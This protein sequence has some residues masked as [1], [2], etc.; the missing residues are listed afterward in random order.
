MREIL[1]NTYHMT[2]LVGG[3]FIITS[4]LTKI[5]PPKKINALYGYRTPTSMKIQKAWDFAQKYS[6]NKMILGGFFLIL[7]SCIKLLIG[8]KN[9]LLINLFFVFSVIIYMIFT[10]EKAIKNKFK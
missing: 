7:I 10:T 4:I 9:E 2:L 8:N 3:V 6:S 5:F 1:E